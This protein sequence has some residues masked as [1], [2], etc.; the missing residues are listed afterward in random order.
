MPRKTLKLRKRKLWLQRK[1]NNIL[2][3]FSKKQARTG[4]SVS[5]ENPL[6]SFTIKGVHWA[7]KT[8]NPRSLAIER[9]FGENS[10]T[11]RLR[12]SVLPIILAFESKNELRKKR[13]PLVTIH[14][15]IC[16]DYSSRKQQ[17]EIVKQNQQ[18]EQPQ[19]HSLTHNNWKRIAN[20]LLMR[21]FFEVS[22]SN[23]LTNKDTNTK[24]KSSSVQQK[25]IGTQT[26]FFVVTLSML[27]CSAKLKIQMQLRVIYH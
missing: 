1:Q 14:N 26:V 21:H 24:N 5:K 6:K 7:D 27:V 3:S 23:S 12:D 15:N 4:W 11:D 13:S 8:E 16:T 9:S 25:N 20:H 2:K 10:P 18:P 17:L 22:H 19:P